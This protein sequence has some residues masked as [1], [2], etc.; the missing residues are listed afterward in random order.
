MHSNKEV[1][2]IGVEMIMDTNLRY[3]EL[4]TRIYGVKKLYKHNFT[5]LLGR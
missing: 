1:V 4:K 2:V 5:L 3:H